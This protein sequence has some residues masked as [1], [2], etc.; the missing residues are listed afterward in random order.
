MCACVYDTEAEQGL[1]QREGGKL[2][3][4]QEWVMGLIMS[5]GGDVPASECPSKTRYFM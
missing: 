5:Q 2:G 3:A 4:E 1:F